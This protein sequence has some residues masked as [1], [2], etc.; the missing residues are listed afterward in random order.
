MT[1]LSRDLRTKAQARIEEF[2]S[3][4]D[5]RAR[6]QAGRVLEGLA[7]IVQASTED[8]L[9]ALADMPGGSF[10]ASDPELAECLRRRG[11]GW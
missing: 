8:V 2:S 10:I 11:S 7:K 3:S 9:G 5:Q 4:L 1:E 6:A